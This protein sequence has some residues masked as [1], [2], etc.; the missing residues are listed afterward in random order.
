MRRK[1]Q[2]FTRIKYDPWKKDIKCVQCLVVIQIQDRI[3]II[4]DTIS[5]TIKLAALQGYSK[6]SKPIINLLKKIH[7]FFIKFTTTSVRMQFAQVG[8]LRQ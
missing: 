2:I 6:I 7:F 5:W 8:S 4:K 1:I 3:P